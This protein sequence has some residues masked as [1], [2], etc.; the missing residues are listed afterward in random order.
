MSCPFAALGLEPS[1]T[2]DLVR[3]AYRQLA[4]STHPDGGGD[5]DAFAQLHEVYLE[6]MN[7]AENRPCPTCKSRGTVDHTTGWTTIQLPCP[8]CG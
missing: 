7:I 5:P 6:A 8:T 2:T 4:R 3:A 1:A